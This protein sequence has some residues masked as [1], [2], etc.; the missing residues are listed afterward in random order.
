MPR[1]PIRSFS[2]SRDEEYL[3]VD[4]RR[5]VILRIS[6]KADPA[7]NRKVDE[8]TRAGGANSGSPKR[9]RVV[10]ADDHQEMLEELRRLLSRDFDVVAAV[11][12]GRALI[13]AVARLRPDA[14]VSDVNMPH[15]DGIEAGRRIIREGLCSA[16]VVLTVYNEQQL[17]QSAL[18]SGIRGYVLKTDA[19]EE[20]ARAV[21]TV[22]LGG[23]YV[24]SGL[25]R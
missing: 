16:V 21:Q 25:A 4:P 15:L 14:V 6:S 7:S 12:E 8:T 24:S 5:T 2:G 23:A 11:S 1:P 19:G 10:V 3:R 22:L 9:S 20:L 17:V 13:S 18:E